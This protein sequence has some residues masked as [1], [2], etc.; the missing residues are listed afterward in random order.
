METLH[1]WRKPGRVAT[2]RGM[3]E[4]FFSPALPEDAPLPEADRLSL[5]QAV[6]MLEETSLSIR[7]AG[8][9]GTVAGRGLHG[10]LSQMPLPLRT[11]IE[12]TATAAASDA[13]TFAYRAVLPTLGTRRVVRLPLAAPVAERVATLASGL[14]GGAGGVA[15]TIIELPITTAVLLRSIAR[16]AR[17]EGEDPRDDETRAECLKVLAIGAPTTASP[18]TPAPGDAGAASY[19][20]VRLALAEAVSA[21]TGRMI[22]SNLF[23][24]VAAAVLPRFA[25]GVAL[26]FAGQAVPVAGAAAGGLVNYAFTTHYQEKARGHFIIRRLERTHGEAVVQ[27]LY[28][29]LAGRVSPVR[30]AKLDDGSAAEHPA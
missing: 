3:D 7:I 28:E 30:R 8:V 25:A 12:R 2:L 6:T 1:R 14:A 4:P 9:L 26:K 10:L 22:T 13:I 21:A 16:I 23:P 11:Q 18:S 27:S 17:E 29:K 5:Q 19:Q 20:A 24:R 15:G